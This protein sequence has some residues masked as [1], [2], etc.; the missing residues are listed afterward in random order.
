MLSVLIGLAVLGLAAL[1]TGATAT[2]LK[3]DTASPASG[4][5]LTALNPDVQLSALSCASTGNC[6][7]VGTYDDAIG[8]SQGIL[9]SEAG[10]IWKPSVQ[11]QA[12]VGAS[13]DPFK[14]A[15]GG[16]IAD[17]ACPGA[18]SCVA[19]GRYTDSVGIDHALAITESGGRWERGLKLQLPANAIRAVKPKTGATQDLNL[20]NVACGSV[21]NCVAI[22]NY[23]TNAEVWEG[24]IVTEA[25]GRWTRGIEA[26]LPAGAPIEGQNAFLLY[27]DCV[28]AT[29][30]TLAG[31]YVD[32]SGHQQA[33]LIR[34]AGASW[35]AA[36]DP[37][38]PSDAN[39]DPNIEPTGVSCTDALDCV[40][41]GTYVNPLE[42][43]LGLAF[44]ESHGDWEAATGVT[45]PSGAA[46]ATT[47]GDQTAV[48]SSVSCPQTG[49]CT[50]VGWYFDND[51][52][53]QGLL[54]SEQHGVWQPGAQAAL[55]ANAVGGL[56]K[57]SAGLD[58][59]S[60]ASV[61]NCLATGEYTDLGYDSQ[62][63]LLSESGGVWQ[64]ALES[65]L[66]A[67]AS[68]QQTAA[69]DQS[70]CTAAGDCAVIGE[71]NATH[72]RLLGYTISETN[73]S[74]GRPAA[75]SLPGATSAELKLSLDAILSPYGRDSALAGIRKARGFRF[76]YVAPVAGT[77][78]VQWYATQAGKP[79]LAG[80]GSVS[81]P[82]AGGTTLEVKLTAAGVQLLTGV[83]RLRI[84]VSAGFTPR[85]RKLGDQ[86]TTSTFTLR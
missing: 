16:S 2:T 70:D 20:D 36:P 55:P 75:V 14:A 13:S 9:V 67:H 68:R 26:P 11:A 15:D 65:P 27:A 79:V 1:T 49:D 83:K 66:P 6:A 64:T 76:S 53:G 80:S 52:N 50:A 63:L 73:G 25:R 72:G 18:G 71:F 46:P 54:V 29:G 38:A 42:N 74:F 10:G 33:L 39:V 17:V 34:G 82:A 84:S 57:Q 47:V 7:A 37:A 78:T 59:V 43:S 48:L 19:V 40:A 45:L 58:W 86:H 23:E 24:L 30:C 35:V 69:T 77:A 61:G 44:I 21:G 56:E 8:D 28:G 4:Q 51:E 12:P 60:C 81:V 85:D 32:A 22:G 62:G 41:V 3:P 31:D 5:A